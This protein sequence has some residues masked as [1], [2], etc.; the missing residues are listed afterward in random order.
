MPIFTNTN[1]K[2]ELISEKPF[3]LERDVQKLIETNMKTIFN[4]E[5][6][7]SEYILN[8]LRVDSLGYDEETKSFVII[9]YKRD[10]NFS[11]I[12]QGYAYLA[13][14]LNNKADFTLLYNEKTSKSLKKNDIDWSPQ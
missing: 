5:F 13:L 3:D 4:L 7:T 10:K 2:L 11:V 8:D 12:D 1:G 9:E 14:L 6:I